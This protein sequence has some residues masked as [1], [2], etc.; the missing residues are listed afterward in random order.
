[1]RG[2]VLLLDASLPFVLPCLFKSCCCCCPLFSLVSPSPLFLQ[3]RRWMSQGHTGRGG[4]RRKEEKPEESP[5]QR[6]REREGG[7]TTSDCL[8]FLFFSFFFFTFP[9]FTQT[10]K[11]TLPTFHATTMLSMSLT[12]PKN[13]ATATSVLLPFRAEIGVPSETAERLSASTTET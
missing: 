9:F 12:A 11:K 5:P 7:A 10:Q 13:A 8:F 3:M 1:M 4:A 2:L 6:H